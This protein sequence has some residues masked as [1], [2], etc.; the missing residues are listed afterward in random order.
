MQCNATQEQELC[1]EHP[2]LCSA[3]R[4]Y[5]PLCLQHPCLLHRLDLIISSPLL[6][7]RSR[8]TSYLFEF[9][10]RSSISSDA[11][12]ACNLPLLALSQCVWPWLSSP[13]P[14][15]VRTNA[16]LFK[17][18]SNQQHLERG[19]MLYLPSTSAPKSPGLDTGFPNDLESSTN[20]SAAESPPLNEPEERKDTL[21]A[22]AI[23]PENPFNWPETKKWR[24]TLTAAAVVLLLGLNCT[25]IA[26]PGH[27]VT[28][29]FQVDDSGF[30]NDVWPITAWY[31]VSCNG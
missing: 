22:W 15:G 12:V 5:P 19:S 16:W 14:P 27:L 8:V 25:A 30:P 28:A 11:A 13:E 29:Q 23:H 26:T 17:T 2:S 10:R 6:L 21:H 18:A 24:T 3:Y 20:S 7:V 4:T 31:V 9:S 1:C